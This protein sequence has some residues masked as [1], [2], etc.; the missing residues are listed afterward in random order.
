MHK[1]LNIK[2][3]LFFVF[4]FSIILFGIAC[5]N[6]NGD[7][8]SPQVSISQDAQIDGNDINQRLASSSFRSDLAVAN[9]RIYVAWL[10]SRDG[11][12]NI[13]FNARFNT[14]S[15]WIHEKD[16]QLNSDQIGAELDTVKICCSQNGRYIHVVW[17]DAQPDLQCIYYSYSSNYGESFSSAIALSPGWPY[18]FKGT[19]PAICCSKDGKKVFVAWTHGR[20]DIAFRYSVDGG[21]SWSSTTA[22]DKFFVNT[23]NRGLYLAIGASIDCSDDGRYCH[24]GWLDYRVDGFYAYHRC[25]DSSTQDW[26]AIDHKVSDGGGNKVFL[27]C[28]ADGATVHMIWRGTSGGVGIQYDTS[29]DY[30]DTWGADQNIPTAPSGNDRYGSFC[31]ERNT[32]DIC[33][34]WDRQTATENDWTIMAR[35]RIGG[36]WQAEVQ[37]SKVSHKEQRNNYNFPEVFM[38]GNKVYAVWIDYRDFPDQRVYY[39]TSLDKGLTWNGLGV[40]LNT[41]NQQKSFRIVTPPKVAG[42]EAGVVYSIWAESRDSNIPQIY[43]RSISG[44][45]GKDELIPHNSSVPSHAWLGQIAVNS[46]NIYGL[47][48]TD[49]HGIQDLYFSRSTDNGFHWQSDFIVNVAQGEFVRLPNI[50]CDDKDNV[51]IAWEYPDYKVS[52]SFLDTHVYFQRYSYGIYS[53]S[54]KKKINLLPKEIKNRLPKNKLPKNIVGKNR[55]QQISDDSYNGGTPLLRAD[56]RGNVYVLYQ[57][58]NNWNVGYNFLMVS[59]DRGVSWAGDSLVPVSSYDF[60]HHDF[61]FEDSYVYV[62]FEIRENHDTWIGVW[63]NIN[64]GDPA[65]WDPIQKVI[66]DGASV[67]RKPTIHAIKDKVFVVWQEYKNGNRPQVYYSY[68]IDRAGTWNSPARIDVG[69]SNAYAGEIKSCC[70]EN[71]LHVA[72]SN[73]DLESKKFSVYYGSVDFSTGNPVVSTPIR[74]NDSDADARR[75]CIVCSAEAVYVAWQDKKYGTYDILG[76]HSTDAG[77]AWSSVTRWN[78]NST[79]HSHSIY[80][81]LYISSKWT[82]CLWRDYRYGL[83][84][85]Y[86]QH[87]R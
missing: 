73:Y 82:H 76:R 4:M 9:G 51:Y 18:P 75:P 17:E 59:R 23:D 14:S 20:H 25:W 27:K 24:I 79:G 41:P 83:N 84:V 2:S 15:T 37:I 11:D 3:G 46:E 7:S 81:R 16:L 32:G 8:D 67:S 45:S 60:L 10:D 21:L 5:D 50:T 40:S 66:D 13:Y 38:Q 85:F 35:S 39:N 54:A 55:S 62:V 49:R 52:G 33:V 80:P 1:F 48:V 47:W 74:L 53:S 77:K 63:R 72:W 28:S 69:I 57:L 12:R 61:T 30:G 56:N 29:S 70:T 64:Y 43:G 6:E 42:D 19:L 31:C 26:R 34:V 71:M 58:T 86:E 68:S 36:V 78:T 22:D 65:G 44:S 87:A